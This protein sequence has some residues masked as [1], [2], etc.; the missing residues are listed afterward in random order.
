MGK[1]WEYLVVPTDRLIAQHESERISI[2]TWLE[3]NFDGWGEEEWELVAFHN[4]RA[5]F[6]RE[7][8]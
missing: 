7:R 1:Q 4:D 8:E 3:E 2:I 6:K 5:Y